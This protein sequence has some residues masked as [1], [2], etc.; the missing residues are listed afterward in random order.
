MSVRRWYVPS[1]CGDYR[2]TATV[3]DKGERSGYR[4][5]GAEEEAT[6]SLLTVT[7][8]TPVEVKRLGDFL[9]H[10][11]KQGWVPGLA[12][13]AESGT[14]ELIIRAPIWEAAH[15]LLDRKGTGRPGTLTSVVSA[16]GKVTS[17]DGVGAEAEALVKSD[18]AKEAV[19][20]S[21]PTLCCPNC[22]QGPEKR[23]SEVLHAFCTQAQR[24]SWDVHGFLVCYGNLT[25]RAYRI[26]HRKSPLAQQQG[27][28]AW[29][30]EGGHLMHCHCANL[31]PPEEALAIKLTLEKREHWIRNRSG[32][33]RADPGT[34][35]WNPFMPAS[36][37]VMDGVPDAGVTRSIAAWMRMLGVRAN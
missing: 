7:D 16:D 24:E 9:A 36:A 3:E 23:A 15:A 35:F 30:I 8:P 1:W 28:P 34:K 19:T 5:P 17:V 6:L 20:T 33:L 4:E 25:G 37:Q 26:A 31:P 21:R 22:V 11:R 29:D 32:A 12:G 27:K 13:V 18:D 2:L 14:S 10:A